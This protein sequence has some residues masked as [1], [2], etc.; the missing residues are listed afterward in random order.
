MYTYSPTSET[1]LSF[2]GDRD[3]L[4]DI[5]P[6]RKPSKTQSSIFQEGDYNM[7]TRNV[8]G[9]FT[10]T[11]KRD[12]AAD[13]AAAGVSTTRIP[14]SHVT[15]KYVAR[16][17]DRIQD[18]KKEGADL[19]RGHTHLERP[20]SYVEKEAQFAGSDLA[21]FALH[22]VFNPQLHSLPTPQVSS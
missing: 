5:S 13:L 4:D 6:V 17:R 15:P 8:E 18:L 1:S 3:S 20:H 16:W 7:T 9:C 22:E 21:L 14:Y 10:S 12:F 11:Q 19:M 2:R